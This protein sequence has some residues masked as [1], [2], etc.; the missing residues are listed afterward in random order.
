MKGDNAESTGGVVRK[1]DGLSRLLAS[2]RFVL[3][4]PAPS[5]AGLADLRCVRTSL[6]REWERAGRQAGAW[7]GEIKVPNNL[8]HWLDGHCGALA[9]DGWMEGWMQRG[10]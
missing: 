10:G 2:H 3:P 7:K 4:A 8:E 6:C 5:L 1:P 9:W